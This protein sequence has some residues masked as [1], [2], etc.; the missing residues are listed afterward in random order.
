MKILKVLTSVWLLLVVVPIPLFYGMLLLTNGVWGGLLALVLTAGLVVLIV[1]RGL[2]GQIRRRPVRTVFIGLLAGAQLALFGYLCVPLGDPS[3]MPP[4][5][6]P[7]VSPEYWD[8]S[9]GS[10]IASYHLPSQ[11]PGEPKGTVLYIH[12]GP[13]GM[14]GTSNLRFLSGLTEHGYEVYAYDQAGGGMSGLL[15]PEEYSHQRNIDDL[16][17]VIARIPSG[18]LTAIGQSY[19]STLLASALADERIQPHLTKAVFSEPGGLPITNAN[20]YANAHVPGTPPQATPKFGGRLPSVVSAPRVMLRVALPPSS[21]F[22]SQEETVAAQTEQEQLDLVRYT[23]CKDKAGEVMLQGN[24]LRV[25]MVTNIRVATTMN[26]LDLERFSQTKVPA[27]LMLGECSYVGRKE[28]LAY[29]HA[30]PAIE[31]TQYFQGMGHSLNSPEVLQSLL[32][33]IED[34]PAPLPNYPQKTDAEQFINEGR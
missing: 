9:T 25:N 19:G 2:R 33:F 3:A 28:Q 18:N 4:A 17:E 34:S 15:R 12:G 20:D 21:L 30:Y 11:V 8:L 23:V 22:V 7:G 13:G 16:A 5:T 14:I 32:S 27:M 31:R 24:P 29:L 6:P 10:R 1:W 26:T